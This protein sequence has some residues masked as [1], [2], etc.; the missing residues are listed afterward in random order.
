MT[1]L[2][3]P[4]RNGE[5]EIEKFES[6]LVSTWETVRNAKNLDDTKWDIQNVEEQKM[7]SSQ[8]SKTSNDSIANS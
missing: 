7:E 8:A 1:Q 4:T 2:E 5:S 6:V 3:A